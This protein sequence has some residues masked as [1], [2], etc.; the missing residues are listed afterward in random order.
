MPSTGNSPTGPAPEGS[1]ATGPPASKSTPGEAAAALMTAFRGSLG[2]LERALQRGGLKRIKELVVECKHDAEALQRV[3][4]ELDGET[5]NQCIAELRNYE[6]KAIAVARK[7][8]DDSID[9]VEALLGISYQPPG[10]SEAEKTTRSEASTARTG[11]PP[12]RGGMSKKGRGGA[13]SSPTS[14]PPENPP[15]REDSSGTALGDN[16][17][18]PAGS[19]PAEAPEHYSRAEEPDPP[20]V[21]P[22]APTVRGGGEGR[23]GRGAGRGRGRAARAQRRRERR[24]QRDEPDTQEGNVPE[25]VG[26][27]SPAERGRGGGRGVGHRRPFPLMPRNS[28]S[29]TRSSLTSRRTQSSLAIMESYSVHRADPNTI[30]PDS[31]PLP[32]DEEFRAYFAKESITKTLRT[33]IISKFTGKAND[34]PRFKATFYPHVH[35]Q[36]EPAHLKAMALDSL[37]DPEVREE[38]FGVGLGNSEYDYAERLERL[39]RMFGGEERLIDHSLNKIKE[40]RMQSRRDYSKLRELVNTI[41][42]FVKGVGRRDANSLSLREHLREGMPPGLLKR[43]IEETAEKGLEDT[44]DHMLAWTH[45]NVAA[46]FK[47]KEFEALQEKTPKEAK[48]KRDKTEAKEKHEPAFA[49]LAESETSSTSAGEEV[50][51]VRYQTHEPCP[52]CNGSHQLYKCEAFFYLVPLERRKFV[53]NKKLCMVC[54][55]PGHEARECKFTSY[56]CKFGCKSRHNS[57]LH[58][59]AE[60]Y[61]KLR[62]GSKSP[63]DEPHGPREEPHGP[64][65][66]LSNLVYSMDSPGPEEPDALAYMARENSQGVPRGRKLRA[67]AVT[68]LVIQATNPITNKTEK[69]YAMADTGASNTHVSSDLGR[70]LGLR[71]TLTPFIVGSHGGRVEEYEAMD[72]QV[73]LSAVDDSYKRITQAKCYPNPCG[74]LEAIDWRGVQAQ[75]AHLKH[76]PLPEGPPNRRI[77]VILGTDCLDAMIP[78]APAVMGE[79]G[80][81]CAM[82]SKLGWI[83]GGRTAPRRSTEQEKVE[84]N[85]ARLRPENFCGFMREMSP[86]ALELEWQIES[87]QRE[88]ELA[89]SYSPKRTTPTEEKAVRAFTQGITYDK[90][91]YQVPLLWKGPERPKGNYQQALQL[92]FR[93]EAHMKRH[94]D[95]EIKFLETITKW[96]KN[97][98]GTLVPKHDHSGFFIPSFMVVR[99]DKSTTK[100]RLI[101]NGAYEFEGRSIN[102]YLMTGPS[103]MKR[104]WDVLAR[105]RRGLY[106][107]ACDIESMFLNIRVDISGGDP[108]YLRVLFRDPKTGDIRALQCQTHVFGLTQ[109]P[110]VAMEVVRRHAFRHRAECPYAEQTVSEDIIMDDIILSS[111]SRERVIRTQRELVSLFDKASMNIHKWVTN[112]PDL[113]ER[114]PE[115]SRAES[116]TLSGEEDQL[117]CRGPDEARPTVK[118][119][120]ILYHAP[121]DQLQFFAPKAPEVWTMR[122]LASYVMQLFDPLELLSPIVQKGRRLTQLLWRMK[123]KWDEP[124]SGELEVAANSY[125]QMLATIH[126]LHLPRCLRGPLDVSGWEIICFVDASSH[127]MASCL[128]QRTLY[129][130]GTISSQL[131]CSKMK[132]VPVKKQE[133]IPRVETQAGVIG[134]RLAFD[135]A[136]AY[137]FSIDKVTFF[138]D[139][140]TVLWWLRT[141]NPLSIFV[142]NRICQ[143]LDRTR[144]AQW[145]HIRTNENPADIPTRGATPTVLKNSTLWWEGPPF[146]QQPRASWPVQPTIFPTPEAEEEQ[147]SLRDI[148]SNLTFLTVE[149]D[150]IKFEPT[151]EGLAYLVGRYAS[152][153]KGIKVA[154]KVWGYVA[155]CLGKKELSLDLRERL[156]EMKLICYDQGKT[157]KHVMEPLAKTGR[158][159]HT[160]VPLRPFLGPQGEL[161]SHS[162]L[163]NLEHLELETRQPIILGKNSK[164]SWEIL[165]DIHTKQL[166]HCG[167]VNTLLAEVAKRYLLI[168]GRTKARTICQE[169][170]WCQRRKSPRPIEILEPPLHP[171][172]G[173][174]KLRAFAE[175]G[176]DM[177]GP[178]L[179]KHGKTRAKIKTYIL[180]FVCC[181]TRAVN[182]EAVDEASTQ[183][184]KM[185]FE[186][187]CSRYGCPDH[188]YSDNGSNFVGLNNELQ[189]QYRLWEKGTKEWGTEWPMVDWRF[190]PPYSPRWNGHV[191]VMVKIF[192]KTLR[193]LMTSNT[194][195][196]RTEEFQTLCAMAS[197]MMN[198][199]PLIQLGTPGDRE[200][201]TPAHFLLAGNPY[202]GLGPVLGPDASLGAKKAAADRLAHDLWERLQQEYLKAQIK[203]TKAQSA[204]DASLKVGD[205]VMVLNEK[206]PI[207]LWAIGSV[208]E[209]RTGADGMARKFR[210]QI[211]KKANVIRSATS[212]ALIK[213]DS[214]L[215]N[216]RLLH[217]PK[218]FRAFNLEG[219]RSLKIAERRERALRVLIAKANFEE[220]R[221]AY[222]LYKTGKDF[223]SYR[224]KIPKR[225]SKEAAEWASYGPRKAASL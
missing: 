187:H 60:D 64:R 193:E 83:L 151:G 53:R 51:E 14:S 177:A 77:E 141:T 107:L 207:G 36:R 176:V 129:V 109:S 182:V 170:T 95:Q 70:R 130:G 87:P 180:I 216:D 169:C 33:K 41:Y 145:K 2:D 80:D 222:Q 73:Q 32:T 10:S 204:A 49:F 223:K 134:V 42:F 3:R 50:S 57:D 214:T 127:T 15:Q 47:H 46:H 13:A 161:R 68:T 136:T 82:L 85:S 139:S 159:P 100:Y 34:Y 102:D 124:L 92:F 160:F 81:P 29:T 165:R 198:R 185:A 74:R 24:R 112:L 79:E 128:Y 132:L 217:D 12:L 205:R 220:E 18:E 72:C 199:R 6:T 172:R 97:E 23:N 164:L 135:L 96:L 150:K 126:E 209:A 143:I 155:L 86:S 89:D 131:I 110:F 162:R 163:T 147:A 146:L 48:K 8:Y 17:G 133:S 179:I 186:R 20:S 138:T 58:V 119:L 117:F 137:H 90:G 115:P 30:Y 194:Q 59:S 4:N 88:R 166:R 63:K 28:G 181:A 52:K 26:R 212:L 121:T 40:L 221:C 39:E 184:C 154:A 149:D 43:Y 38:I 174:L 99:T 206:T 75:W 123:C 197:G 125:A 140:T 56:K 148:V 22:T 27:S 25:G 156:V 98:W 93:Q 37:M 91:R 175:T 65:E 103:R 94:P 11:G 62:E 218:T 142:A 54:Y 210:L 122:T 7:Y 105:S 101:L 202:V 167:G 144:L 120:G 191:E 213:L 153:R 190:A 5:V 1:E 114:L 178:F 171:N 31:W 69:V 113:W 16:S 224:I 158:V 152:L 76:L 192:K 200:V 203:Y 118:T 67:V 55:G 188:V 183:S 84:S 157:M 35:V 219:R 201:L 215:S 116:Y 195:S 104:V 66:E 44:L 71:G 108:R 19:A 225:K 173:G 106:L 208:L 9:T 61:R 189:R 211:G 168:A 196:L 45:R 78:V 111:S 21:P